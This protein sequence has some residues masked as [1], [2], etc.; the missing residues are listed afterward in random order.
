MVRAENAR[1]E[2]VIAKR[3]LLHLRYDAATNRSQLNAVS[4]AST[5]FVNNTELSVKTS[6]TAQNYA[7]LRWLH[8]GVLDRVELLLAQ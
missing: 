7:P 4:R 8:C 6:T 5:D 3:N 2:M 1:L